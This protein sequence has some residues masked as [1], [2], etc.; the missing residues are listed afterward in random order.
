MR[1]G[2]AEPSHEKKTSGV[3]GDRGKIIFPVQR[4]ASR[5]DKPYNMPTSYQ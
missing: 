4:T 5:I 1:N 3:N 2:K